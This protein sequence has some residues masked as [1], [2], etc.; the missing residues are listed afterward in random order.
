M[1]HIQIANGKYTFVMSENNRVEDVLR[2]GEPW[3]QGKIAFQF[4]GC[5]NAMLAELVQL[6]AASSA[7]E[8]PMPVPPP[9]EYS[10]SAPSGMLFELQ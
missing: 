8:P 5:I 10:H 1:T 9:P 7:S 6:R 2:G 4:N 3:T